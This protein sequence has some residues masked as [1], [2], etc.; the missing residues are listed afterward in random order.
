LGDADNP[1]RNKTDKP[2]V[3][4]PMRPLGTT[5]RLTE[6]PVPP[7]ATGPTESAQRASSEEIGRGLAGRQSSCAGSQ[8]ESAGVAFHEVEQLFM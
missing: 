4:A 1:E 6:T 8:K 7:G 2:E 5:V 3:P